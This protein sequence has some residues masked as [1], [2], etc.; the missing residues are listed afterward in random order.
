MGVDRERIVLIKE[1]AE[2][3]TDKVGKLAA[4]EGL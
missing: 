4:A 3:N 2:K 1:Q